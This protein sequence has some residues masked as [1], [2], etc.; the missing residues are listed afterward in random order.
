MNPD[1]LK[2]NKLALIADLELGLQSSTPCMPTQFFGNGTDTV[3]PIEW[4]QDQNNVMIKY[5]GE[6]YWEVKATAFLFLLEMLGSEEENE[7]YHANS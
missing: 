3:F 4:L 5:G 7:D 6:E 1:T 2:A